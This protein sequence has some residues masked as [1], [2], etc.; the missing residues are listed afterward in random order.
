MSNESI[1]SERVEAD[2]AEP[3]LTETITRAA[4]AIW[5]LVLVRG[6]LAIVFGILAIIAPAVAL[7]GIVYVFAAYAI[8]DGIFGIAHA[9]RVRERHTGWGWLVAQGVVSVLAGI[10]AA[11]FP[12]LAG[13][14]GALFVLWTIVVFAIANG[15]AGIPAAAALADGGRKVVAFVLAIA[16]ILFGVLLSVLIFLNPLLETVLALIWVVGIY[17]VATGVMLLVLAIQAR[18]AGKRLVESGAL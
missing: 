7:L 13:A 2:G 4:K 15:I 8:V 10:A 11:I 12:G 16:S 3:D 6:I 17:A 1:N 5:W 9:I 18:V 14:V